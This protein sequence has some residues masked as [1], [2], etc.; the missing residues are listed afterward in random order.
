V[1]LFTALLTLPLAPVRGVVWVADQM[2]QEAERQLYDESSIRAELLQLE[3]D[4]EEGV[5]SDEEIRSREDELLERLAI[6]RARQAWP[7]PDSQP[8]P[9]EEND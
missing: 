7:A 9:F 8:I 4:A 2:T 1:G 5:L 6:S 3:L